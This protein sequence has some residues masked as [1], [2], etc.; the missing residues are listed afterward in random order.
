M[1]KVINKKLHPY[2]KTGINGWFG[3]E[4]DDNDYIICP[5]CGEVLGMNY[6]D[7]AGEQGY[8]NQCP[9]CKQ[10]LDYSE[11]Y[12]FE[13]TLYFRQ[14]L[15]IKESSLADLEAKLAE[16]EK[17]NVKLKGVVDS[18]DK[19]KQYHKDAKQLIFLN[20]DNVYADGHKLVIE[21][22][23]QDKIS[24]AVEQLEQLRIK[25]KN[26]VEDWNSGVDYEFTDMLPDYDIYEEIDNQIKELKEG[27]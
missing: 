12:D 7:Y 10:E 24:F 23:N 21:K 8:N 22:A 14:L 6:C 20:P 26:R 18:F 5:M 27:K 16:K 13:D 9:K 3:E 1:S 2:Y 4:V 19:L 11:I 15:E 25:I 17:E